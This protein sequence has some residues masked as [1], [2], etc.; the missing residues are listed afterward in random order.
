MPAGVCY[1]VEAFEIANA[2]R[3][4]EVDLIFKNLQ[5]ETTLLTLAL[6]YHAVI[7]LSR[8]RTRR[9]YRLHLGVRAPCRIQKQFLKNKLIKIFTTV[10]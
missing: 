3:W 1:L 9:G 7:L 8:P 5:C 4:L 2:L 6:T 10:L